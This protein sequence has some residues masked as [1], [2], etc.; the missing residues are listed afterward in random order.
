MSTAWILKIFLEIAVT[1]SN[2]NFLTFLLKSLTGDQKTCEFLNIE[3]CVFP[4]LSV[5][6]SLLFVSTQIWMYL[7][8]LW[9][10]IH[11]FNHP[12][13]SYWRQKECPILLGFPF[14]FDPL[15]SSSDSSSSFS[16]FIF[17]LSMRIFMRGSSSSK[18]F[19]LVNEK[20]AFWMN[21]SFET[22]I[23]QQSKQFQSFFF[24]SARQMIQTKNMRMYLFHQNH[25]GHLHLILNQM[26]IQQQEETVPTITCQLPL[27]DFQFQIQIWRTVRLNRCFQKWLT[28]GG[29]LEKC[30]Y[31]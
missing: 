26:K 19:S 8:I 4:Y 25:H 10:S 29:K 24:Q 17:S 5:Y 28:I 21:P 3:T 9:S 20:G 12:Q 30:C 23:L 14:G 7:R 27:H 22:M 18:R 13:N 11:Q 6:T 31:F 15:F 1:W 2:L 16:G